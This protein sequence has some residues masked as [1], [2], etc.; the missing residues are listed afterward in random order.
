VSYTYGIVPR[1]VETAMKHP[2]K[3]AKWAAI[4]H[5][6]HEAGW[7]MS[8]DSDR[9]EF[10]RLQ[11]AQ[12]T[13]FDSMWGIP[14]MSPTMIKNP[15]DL[16]PFFKGENGG[17]WDIGRI[18]AGGDLFNGREGGAGQIKIFPGFA[19]PSF[20]A[21]GA[22]GYTLMS[23]DQF[24][25]TTIPDGKKV[26]AFYRQFTP[27]IVGLGAPSIGLPDSYAQRKLRRAQSGQDETGVDQH[28]TTSA[29]LSSI[30]LKITPVSLSKL[31]GRTKRRFNEELQ[32]LTTEANS[33]QRS[34]ANGDYHPMATNMTQ[35]ERDKAAEEIAAEKIEKLYRGI[36]RLHKKYKY[37]FDGD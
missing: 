36:D 29:L 30:G 35:G 22:V 32:A 31:Q 5:L 12:S 11:E 9:E 27:N 6:A 34:H 24:K 37:I 23:I 4:G 7:T 15:D 33:I 21:A 28:T 10:E 16:L 8:D 26:E 3:V 2:M 17:F 13:G 19:Q 25:G 18:Y 20:G 14:F 1:L